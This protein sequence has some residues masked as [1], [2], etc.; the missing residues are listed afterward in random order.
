MTKDETRELPTMVTL[1]LEG[2]AAF[3][4]RSPQSRGQEHIHEIQDSKRIPIQVPKLADATLLQAS[5]RHP[6]P[7]LQVSTDTCPRRGEVQMVTKGECDAPLPM[8]AQDP[9]DSQIGRD[10]TYRSA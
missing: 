2:S 5:T 3:G 7:Y 1:G 10:S 9:R 6:A 4:N 8:Q